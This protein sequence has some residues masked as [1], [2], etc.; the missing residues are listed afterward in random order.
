MTSITRILLVLTLLGFLIIAGPHPS[1]KAEE[2]QF[3]LAVGQWVTVGAYTLVFRGVSGT[4]P[5]YDLYSDS[6]LVARFPSPALPPNQAEYAYG[7]VSI[8][9][10]RMASDGTA[11]TGTI[12]V[13]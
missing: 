12:T 7:N 8:A 1:A 9:T 11:T 2:A 10:T 6:V 3:S 13:R 4:L 5:S